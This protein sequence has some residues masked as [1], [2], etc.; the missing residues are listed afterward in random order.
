MQ[1]AP[2]RPPD[3]AG[4][5]RLAAHR[6]L[7]PARLGVPAALVVA[8]L[9]PIALSDAYLRN[10]LVLWGIFTLLGVSMNIIFGYV[11]ELS[12]GHAGFFGTGAYVSSLLAI[13]LGVSPWIGLVCAGIAGGL[14]GLAVGYLSLRIRGP[15]FAI[16]T[17]SF[18]TIVYVITLDWTGLTR[19]PLGLPGI[20][21]PAIGDFFFDNPLPYYYLVLAMTVIALYVTWRLLASRTGRAMVAIRENEF[22][23]SAL[24]VN[25]FGYKLLAFVISTSIAGVAGSL[26]AHYLLFTSPD[27]LTTQY[28]IAMIIIVVIGGRG[29]L[30]GPILGAAAFVFVP[31]LLRITG[32]LQLVLFA[33]VLILF[34]VFLP[35]GLIQ[36]PTRLTPVW[37]RIRHA[38][39]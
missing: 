18:G 24:G 15:Q 34:I 36:V 3:L 23:A 11:G 22:L 28:V 14:L 13:R 26:Y 21:S 27:T 25:V 5:P 19:G 10:L 30:F 37:T 6:R 9:L 16:V 12:F 1:Q 38:R 31:E 35:K 4:V 29:T 33:A 39:G 20:P 2:N 32:S 17:L 7:T 8:T